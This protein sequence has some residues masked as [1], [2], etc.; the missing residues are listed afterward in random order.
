MTLH[1]KNC[2]INLKE[3]FLQHNTPKKV[4]KIANFRVMHNRKTLLL[5]FFFHVGNPF[6]YN[7]HQHTLLVKYFILKTSGTIKISLSCCIHISSRL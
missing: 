7:K 6:F 2:S 3:K 1:L 5:C 4:N